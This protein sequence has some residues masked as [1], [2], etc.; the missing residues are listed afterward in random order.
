MTI[1]ARSEADTRPQYGGGRRFSARQAGEIVLS[2]I[3]A[4]TTKV[5]GLLMVDPFISNR[6]CRPSQ[7]TELE[8][9][10]WRKS[11]A[12]HNGPRPNCLNKNSRLF[13]SDRFG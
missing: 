12:I 7:E 6:S 8:G 1:P 13:L 11:K 4:G 3:G 10:V 5:I 2:L 9:V